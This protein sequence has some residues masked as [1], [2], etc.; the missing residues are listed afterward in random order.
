MGKP[1]LLA[2]G[3]AC[4]VGVGSFLGLASGPV[5][6]I[7][8]PYPLPLSSGDVWRQFLIHSLIVLSNLIDNLHLFMEKNT[9]SCGPIEKSL[10]DPL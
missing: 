6:L 5:S 8:K 3:L 7:F 10:W 2:S 1:L 4:F 9:F